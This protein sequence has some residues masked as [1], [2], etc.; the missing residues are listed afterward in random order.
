MPSHQALGELSDA[1]VMLQ[2]QWGSERAFAELYGRHYRRLLDF[3]YGLSRDVQTAE[4]LCHETFLRLWQLRVRYRPS[5]SFPAYLFT[6]A[7]HIWM[8]RRRQARKENC[9]MQNAEC[10]MWD[11]A[12]VYGLGPDEQ[13]RLSELDDRI[14]AALDNLPEEQRMAF[15]L[16]TVEGMSLE[17]IAVVMQC[18]VNTVRSRRLL[19]IKRL[20]E[21]LRGLLVL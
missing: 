20:R 9:R 17:D 7:R 13:A 14:F 1:E 5:G 3:F 10:G 21:V 15:I 11:V 6:I 2:A 8:E 4:D 16:R 12:D 18:P 19:A